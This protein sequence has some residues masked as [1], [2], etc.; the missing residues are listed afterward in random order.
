MDK[1]S[2]LSNIN[3]NSNN[4]IIKEKELVD[5]PL[6]VTI[7]K[8]NKILDQLKKCVCKIKNEKGNGTGFFCYI[9]Y[10]DDKI[11]VL[12]TNYHVI[13]D[14]IIKE[15]KNIIV[16]LDDDSED[17]IIELDTSKKKIYTSD[18]YDTTIIEIKKGKEKINDFLDLDKNIFK[19]KPNLCNESIYILHYP[20]NDNEQKASISYGR[21]KKIETDGFNM[22]HYCCTEKGSSGSPILLLTNNKIIG[23][24]KEGLSSLFEFNKGTFLKEPIN[25]FLNN[26]NQK[27]SQSKV[28]DDISYLNKIT[29]INI[30]YDNN[31][32]NLL[33]SYNYNIYNYNF[34]RENLYIQNNFDKINPNKIYFK[35]YIKD[36]YYYEINNKLFEYDSTITLENMLLDFLSKTK[37]RKTL[38]E[39]KIFFLYRWRI[40]NRKKDLKKKIGEIFKSTIKSNVF[41]IQ[42]SEAGRIFNH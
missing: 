11:P 32:N 28:E 22:N 9:P 40:I 3:K 18:K 39:D 23:I 5:Y 31:K 20:K 34:P 37:Y 38:D 4:D 35:F 8:T 27:I 10:N 36:D 19:E 33:K 13:D 7:E 16:T 17:K 6:P 30:N 21:F 41:I 1:P 24:H 14:N 42:V 29:D 25:E 12:M 2:N 26:L 15:N